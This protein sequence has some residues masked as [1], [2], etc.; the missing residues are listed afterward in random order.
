MTAV[1]EM[2]S[3]ERGLPAEE[4]KYHGR[5][6]GRELCDNACLA[7]AVRRLGFGFLVRSI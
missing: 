7:E 6:L 3:V 4:I 1:D 5:S 2:I